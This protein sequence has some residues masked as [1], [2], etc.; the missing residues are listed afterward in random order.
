MRIV[1]RIASGPEAGQQIVFGPGDTRLVG[2]ARNADVRL[3]DDPYLS[4][5]HVGLYV[6]EAG[7]CVARDLYSSNGTL[8][9][10]EPLEE[11]VLKDGDRITAGETELEV[12][13]GQPAASADADGD[14]TIKLPREPAA[15]VAETVADTV[16]DTAAETAT[17]TAAEATEAPVEANEPRPYPGIPA[18]PIEETIVLQ[19]PAAAA[20][21][22]AAQGA[23]PAWVA[24]PA[25]PRRRAAAPPAPAQQTAPAASGVSP[26]RPQ[27]APAPAPAPPSSAS[28]SGIMEI[29]KPA[30]PPPPL[31]PRVIINIPSADAPAA[32]GILAGDSTK[33]RA[34]NLPAMLSAEVEP[35]FA[36]IDAAREKTVPRIVTEAGPDAISLYRGRRADRLASAAPY[37]VRMDKN[38]IGRFASELWG[39]GTGV[40]FGSTA[41]MEEL[42]AHFRRL[43]IVENEA[44][45]TLYFRFYDPRVLR[46]FLPSCTPSQ[47][48]RFFGPVAWFIAETK[49]N[50]ARFAPPPPQSHAQGSAA[51]AE[52]EHELFGL[53]EEQLE[54]FRRDARERF[55]EGMVALLKKE[56]A[57]DVAAWPD[58]EGAVRAAVGRAEGYGISREDDLERFLR[59]MAVLGPTFD[60]D[61]ALP[62]AGEILRRR[63]IKAPRRLAALKKALTERR[64]G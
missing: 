23:V 57:K 42:R 15:A 55:I 34:A 17:E 31:L 1:L 51:P 22:V 27:P 59:L 35:I 21:S 33:S 36:L 10:G 46:V 8:L 3:P 5:L 4:D 24:Q 29:P 45:E 58:L 44:R 53:R 12:R 26:S 13:I 2:R 16:A 52:P 63:V 41:S 40:L 32:G 18:V 7:V 61:D 47:A 30:P 43:L 54:L 62:W 19:E 39:Q 60:D 28:Q 37:L 56:H 9:N 50:A 64:L 6:D 20:V 14:E 25:Q 48:R 49:S 38:R 11:A